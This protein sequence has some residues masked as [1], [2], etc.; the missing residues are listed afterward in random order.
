MVEELHIARELV[1]ERGL[2]RGP[3]R[4]LGRRGKDEDD[5]EFLKKQKEKDKKT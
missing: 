1:R 2:L 3:L 5:E 4:G